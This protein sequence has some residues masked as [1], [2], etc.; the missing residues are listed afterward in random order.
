MFN[1]LLSLSPYI[2]GSSFIFA[3]FL[4]RFKCYRFL[5][6][7][8][9]VLGMYKLINLLYTGNI[10]EQEMYFYG[11]LL[12]AFLIMFLGILEHKTVKLFIIL[13]VPTLFILLAL[14]NVKG[15]YI[16]TTFYISSGLSIMAF[17][18]YVLYKIHKRR[19]QK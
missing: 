7:P 9:Y 19:E 16:L 6:F 17:I 2:Y 11:M 13:P 14:L 12:S 8:I 15:Y 10:V 1:S 18:L 5:L 4:T 3:V